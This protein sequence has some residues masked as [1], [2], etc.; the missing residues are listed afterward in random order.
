M[1]A[2]IS[3]F[4]IIPLCIFLLEGALSYSCWVILWSLLPRCFSRSLCGIRKYLRTRLLINISNHSF[5]FSVCGFSCFSL[6]DSM[7]VTSHWYARVFLRWCSRF[8][9]S[10]CCSPRSF[11]LRFHLVLS[12][13]PTSSFTLLSR[14]DSSCSGDCMCTHLLR[15]ANPCARS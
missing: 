15:P 11:S 14:P 9:P 5:S 2:E 4:R 1:L 6:R 3:R 7:T 12:Q 10:T 8:S 13:R